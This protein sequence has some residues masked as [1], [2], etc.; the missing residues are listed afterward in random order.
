[1]E[2]LRAHAFKPPVVHFI[3]WVDMWSMGELFSLWLTPPDGP[4]PWIV[5]ANQFDVYAYGLPDGGRL[6]QHLAGAGPQQFQ[7]SDWFV[8]RLHEAVEAW[9]GLV[10]RAAIVVLR[11]TFGASVHDDEVVAA[12]SERPAWLSDELPGG[13]EPRNSIDHSE[14]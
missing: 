12:L 3:E 4:L 14:G 1:V 11:H 7:E 5:C 6:V 10:D 8:W 13:A 9:E 2:Q